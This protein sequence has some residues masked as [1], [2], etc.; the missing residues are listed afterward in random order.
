MNVTTL[1]CCESDFKVYLRRRCQATNSFPSIAFPQRGIPK[2]NT[3][4]PQR[5]YAE[6]IDGDSPPPAFSA[7]GCTSVILPPFLPLIQT[8]R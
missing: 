3:R 4:T 8:K 7:L 2:N 1:S 5:S 6:R